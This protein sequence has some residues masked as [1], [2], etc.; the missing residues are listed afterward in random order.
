[1]IG[2]EIITG[3]YLSGM[4]VRCWGPFLFRPGR[5]DFI[6][7]RDFIYQTIE[8]VPINAVTI[9][10]IVALNI[11]R[12]LRRWCY[13]PPIIWLHRH[14]V[15]TI[16]EYKSFSW[17]VFRESF[18]LRPSVLRDRQEMEEARKTHLRAQIRQRAEMDAILAEYKVA[19]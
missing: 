11:G 18:T 9:P 1:M 15:F 19:S 13:Y 16:P 8:T 7:S 12:F 10:A 14:Y 4:P 3:E 6:W 5:T 17:R 2:K